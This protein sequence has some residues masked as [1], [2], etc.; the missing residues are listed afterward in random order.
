MTTIA[1][2]HKKKQIAYDSRVIRDD[3]II[4]TDEAE[5]MEEF[6]DIQ[7]IGSGVSSDIDELTNC[8]LNDEEP[9]KNNLRAVLIVV[10]DGK[11][12]RVGCCDGE[13]WVNPIDTSWAEGS[14]SDFAL[15]ALDL[16][17]TAEQ[18]INY[19]KTR[20]IYTGGTVRVIDVH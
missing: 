14:G 17:Y 8:Y 11:L 19:V 10:R 12:Y 4:I 13:V 6:D 7:I 18:A 3:T 15:A 5:K 20:D 1:Y 16:G 9:S 2:D